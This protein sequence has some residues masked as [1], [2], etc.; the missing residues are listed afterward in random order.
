MILEILAGGAAALSAVA[1]ILVLCLL[2]QGARQGKERRQALSY[3]QLRA[4]LGEQDRQTMQRL[5][6]LKGQK[7]QRPRSVW[8]R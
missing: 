5:S 2:R 3:E 6:L 1:V 7:E 8:G 4:E